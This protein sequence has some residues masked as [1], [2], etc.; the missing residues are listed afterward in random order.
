[1]ADRVIASDAPVV[2]VAWEDGGKT[3]LGACTDRK[4]RLWD[5]ESGAMLRVRDS[6]PASDAEMFVPRV[7]PGRQRF[8]SMAGI[9]GVSAMAESRD[10]KWI[11]AGSYDTDVRVWKIA[12]AELV[13]LIDE[14]KVSMFDIE[15]SPD[16]KWLAMAGADR[17]VYVWE[18]GTWK[19]SRK[20]TGQPELIVAL[21]FSPDG[22]RL[23]TGGFN[24]ANT[25]LPVSV[26][27]WDASTGRMLKQAE[28]KRT[29][30]DV[31]FSPDGARVAAAYR[32]K[33]LRLV[34]IG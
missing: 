29:V 19:L 5:A 2:R 8:A 1:M 9:G 17:T 16:G 3:V 32:E 12:D 14:L 33:E 15:F 21:H 22:R 18:T 23:V 25:K 7:L 6:D 28:V 11:A 27:V 13:R 26:I 31:A 34:E 30:T 20:I 4:V 24:D 10:G